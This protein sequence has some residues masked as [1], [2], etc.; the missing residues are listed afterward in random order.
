MVVMDNL[1]TQKGRR[2]REII[3]GSSCKLAYPPPHSPDLNPSE[4]AF[5]KVKGLR[6]QAEARTRQSLIEAMGWVLEEPA[7]DARGFCEH[8]GYRS[9]DQLP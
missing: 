2:M 9:T 7:R 4:Q 3:E 5:S 8:R 6:R 1:S